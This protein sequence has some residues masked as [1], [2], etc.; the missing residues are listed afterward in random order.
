MRLIIPASLGSPGS[1][2]L[3]DSDN[4]LLRLSQIGICAGRWVYG[5]SRNVPTL[6]SIQDVSGHEKSVS[7]Q[8]VF[9]FLGANIWVKQILNKFYMI[10]KKVL[11]IVVD[12]EDHHQVFSLFVSE[13][14]NVYFVMTKI[15][16]FIFTSVCL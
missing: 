3:S 9:I 6:Y 4:R 5:Y 15:F 12:F 11:P 16:L 2:L 8:D 7:Q 10:G 1:W 14:N 13:T